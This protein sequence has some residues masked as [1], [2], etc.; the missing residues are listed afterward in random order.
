MNHLQALDSP[1]S[2]QSC[3]ARESWVRECL[4]RLEGQT[5]M[6]RSAQLSL[7]HK[8]TSGMRAQSRSGSVIHC[9]VFERLSVDKSEDVVVDVERVGFWVQREALCKPQW[10]WRVVDLRK[11]AASESLLVNASD[12]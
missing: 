6:S 9:R 5:G 4:H 2:E 1:G 8:S 3:C 7:C 11:R 12:A 10:R